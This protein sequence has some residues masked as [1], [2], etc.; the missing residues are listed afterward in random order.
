[1]PHGFHPPT[2][3]EPTAELLREL[4]RP[5]A[6]GRRM[7][8]L[9]IAPDGRRITFEK[10]IKAR[11]YGP[12]S[13]REDDHR[14]VVFKDLYSGR[15]TLLHWTHFGAEP[16]QPYGETTDFFVGL[17]QH[18]TDVSRVDELA[19]EL[20]CATTRTA[21]LKA[22]HEF[23]AAEREQARAVQLQ[24]ELDMLLSDVAMQTKHYGAQG[25]DH[26]A[27]EELRAHP[28]YRLAREHCLL[29]AGGD[30][31]YSALT[32]DARR[33]DLLKGRRPVVRAEY[34]DLVETQP[35]ELTAAVPDRRHTRYANLFWD[36]Q[37]D[38]EFFV[39]RRCPSDHEFSRGGV[40]RPAEDGDNFATLA[41][42]EDQDISGI[43]VLADDGGR[44]PSADESVP[45]ARGL[46]E[47]WPVYGAYPSYGDHGGYGE[48]WAAAAYG[49]SCD[50]SARRTAMDPADGSCRTQRSYNGREKANARCRVTMDLAGRDA[51]EWTVKVA[52]CA[53]TFSW[54]LLFWN[55]RDH[56]YVVTAEVRTEAGH[57]T[58]FDADTAAH[59]VRRTHGRCASGAYAGELS[60][61]LPADSGRYVVEW[62]YDVP[63]D[64][65]DKND[66]FPFGFSPSFSPDRHLAA[67][68][69]VIV[70]TAVG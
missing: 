7:F 27:L 28:F 23:Y 56:R 17:S 38:E 42:S 19:A 13:P 33:R 43:R 50:T 22:A 46:S 63:C 67:R 29:I 65:P 41:L 45:A 9:R 1:M 11:H 47:P 10:E 49:L 35:T 60:F 15:L 61:T 44:L 68:G 54:E 57:R 16:A 21:E 34:G 51:E 39:L 20:T 24:Y 3:D 58:R 64:S 40:P 70:D 18:D 37:D 62:T 52:V 5:G 31:D 66:G 53:D 36:R 8:Q 12:T 2:F 30:R 26:P 6:D 4:E 69:S 48:F 32:H 59:T 55:W 14:Y 25:L